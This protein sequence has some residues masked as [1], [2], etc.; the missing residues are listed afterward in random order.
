[1][2]K[3]KDY[4][5]ILEIDKNS[6]AKEIK[7]AYYRLSKKHHP[8]KNGDEI[9]FH[10]INEAYNVLSEAL[11]NKPTV[12]N[13]VEG[14]KPILP[15]NVADP[16][17]LILPVNVCVSEDKDPKLVLPVIELILDVIV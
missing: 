12:G 10:G 8:D 1:M 2:N 7:S 4:Y 11:F 15:E 13:P 16:L 3:K 5:K 9:L 17:A 14:P 6:T